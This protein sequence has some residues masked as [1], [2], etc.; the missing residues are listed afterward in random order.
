MPHWISSQSIRRPFSSHSARTPWTNSSVAGTTPPSPWTHSKSTA[1]VFS[2]T[3]AFTLSRSLKSA[4]AKPGI[5][6]SKPFWTLLWPVAESVAS[7]RPWN[8]PRMQ[9]IS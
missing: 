8:E 9:T 3:A 5:S 6:G 2:V 1:T 7:V 4:N